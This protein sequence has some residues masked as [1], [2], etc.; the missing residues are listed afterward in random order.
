M[1]ARAAGRGLGA[2]W[3]LW[4]LGPVVLLAV[5]VGIWVSQGSSVVDLIGS[6]PPPADEFDGAP[7]ERDDQVDDAADRR[8]DGDVPDE[9]GEDA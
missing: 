8:D 2:G 5:A 7:P 3:R 9:T 1:E 6:N 4:A